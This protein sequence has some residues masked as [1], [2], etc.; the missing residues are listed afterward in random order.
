MFIIVSNIEILKNFTDWVWSLQKQRISP[1]FIVNMG[2]TFIKITDTYNKDYSFAGAVSGLT[3]NKKDNSKQTNLTFIDLFSG[4]GGIRLGFESACRNLGLSARCVFSS[5]IK[6]HAIS[7]YIENFKD[8]G[9]NG[10]ITQVDAKNI[11]DFDYLLAGFPC[12]SFS[13]AGKR[14]GFADIRGTLFFD[15]IRILKE[16]KPQGFILENVDGL[17]KHDNG[18]TLATVIKEL[19]ILNYNISW[20]VLNASDF[21][22]PQ[23]RKRIY[24][25]GHLNKNINLYNFKIKKSAIKDVIDVNVNASS[26]KTFIDTLLKFYTKEQLAGKSIKDKRGGE[27]NIHSWDIEL[28]G[29]ITKEQKDLMNILLK[30]R[31]MKH[32][33]VKK[34]IVWMDGMPLTTEEISTF[35]QH[36][37]LQE[38][39]DDLT[40][41]G[42]LRYEYPKNIFIE[43]GVKVRK[44]DTSKEKGYNIVAGKLSFPLS[45]ILSEEDVSPTIVATEIGRIAVATEKGIRNF[46][47]QEG[48]RLFGYPRSYQ[49]KNISYSKAFDL[50]GNTVIPPVITAIA[51]RLLSD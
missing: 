3:K 30:K 41:K 37:K 38:M 20:N 33:A 7:V 4:L 25:V 17:V 50:L 23:N 10:D 15:I 51:E 12:Q 16:K 5:E 31:R 39:L 43:N 48:L 22:V 29:E 40:S 21:G 28:K 13:T 42:Y 32:W 6:P 1:S 8:E 47:I 34:D 45:K 24:I 49:M 35:Y 44:Y 14:K 26:A 9:I 2:K 27:N 18:G 19:E 11:P 46:T 36:A